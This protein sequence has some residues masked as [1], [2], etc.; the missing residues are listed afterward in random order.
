[1]YCKIMTTFLICTFLGLTANGQPK[2]LPTVDEYILDF[3]NKG[4]YANQSKVGLRKLIAKNFLQI[5]KIKALHIRNV[6]MQQKKRS[7]FDEE[8]KSETESK[9]FVLFYYAY[10]LMNDDLKPNTVKQNC[11]V[12]QARLQQIYDLNEEEN[13]AGESFIREIYQKACAG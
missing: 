4:D 12:Y 10:E 2:A 6:V 13:E 3:K 5:K 8:N 9:E 1:M 7:Q 11:K